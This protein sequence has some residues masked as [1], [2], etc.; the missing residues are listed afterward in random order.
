MTLRAALVLLAALV[1]AA[2]PFLFPEFGGFEPGAYP[3]PQDDPPVQPA[4]YAFAIWGP[5]Y[6]WLLVSAGYGLLRRREDPA[7]DATR[8][9]LIV[10]LAVGAVW[11]PVAN[12]SPV[13]ASVLI[14]IMLLAALAAVFRAPKTDRGLLAWP[15]G[16]YAGWLT[17]ASVVSLGLLAAGYGLLEEPQAG[18]SG[19]L[20]AA[21]FAG[22]VAY[23][24]RRLELAGPPRA[25]SRLRARRRRPSRP[26]PPRRPP[27]DRLT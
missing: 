22:L 19:A 24:R 20:A 26:R 18:W 16:L 15:L 8:L 21:V 2:G 17:A 27:V 11:L 1:F 14:W 12:A 5:I 13:W 4:G 3:V 25:C 9:P 7:W 23:R 10:S 6:L